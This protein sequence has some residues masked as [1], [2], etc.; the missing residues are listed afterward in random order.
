MLVAYMMSF[1]DKQTL[2]YAAIMGIMEDLR[3][4]GA[5]YSWSSAIFYFGYLAFR[6]V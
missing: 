4:T 1:M 6:L 3:L 2:S 5:E